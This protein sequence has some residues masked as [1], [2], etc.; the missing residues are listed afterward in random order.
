MSI[1]LDPSWERILANCGRSVSACT[2]RV[3]SAF[4]FGVFNGDLVGEVVVGGLE[5]T[6]A[7]GSMRTRFCCGWLLDAVVWLI[8]SL[9]ISQTNE[10][11]DNSGMSGGVEVRR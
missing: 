2:A 6:C 11:M 5:T 9:S 3:A 8:I 1:C 4:D 7:V 10:Q